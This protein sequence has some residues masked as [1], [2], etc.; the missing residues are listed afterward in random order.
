MVVELTMA[1]ELIVTLEVVV[2][3]RCRWQEKWC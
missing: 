1:L 3:G 2:I